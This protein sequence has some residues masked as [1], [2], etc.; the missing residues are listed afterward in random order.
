M[1]GTFRVLYMWGAIKLF[2]VGKWKVTKQTN[3]FFLRCFIGHL[4]RGLANFQAN[5]I[6]I[7]ILI[8]F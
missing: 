5:G 7:S 8:R 2:S 4:P 6:Q 1:V 3:Y